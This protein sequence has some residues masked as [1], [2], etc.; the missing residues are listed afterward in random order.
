M[1]HYIGLDVSMKETSVCVINENGKIVKENTIPTEPREIAS[2]INRLQICVGLVGLESGSLSHWLTEELVSIG[3]P[4]KCIDARHCA[5]FLSMRINKTD[6]ND[7]QGIA[8][9][10]RC[11]IFREVQIKPRAV[12]EVSS[13]LTSRKQLVDQRTRMLMSIRGILKPFG[14]RLGSISKTPKGIAKVLEHILVQGLEEPVKIG[15]RSLFHAIQAM[16]TSIAELESNIKKYINSEPRAQLLMTIP[17]VG[18]IT[19]LKYLVEISDPKRFKKSRSVGAYIGLTP[20]QY[21]SGETQKQGKISKCGSKDLRSLLVE[22]AV[23]LLTRAR[24]WS[25]LK[26]WGLRIMK[27]S[28]LKKAATAVARKLAVIMHQMLI[29]EKPFRFSTK[30]QKV[31]M[32]T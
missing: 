24:S 6:R 26:A 29:T 25:Q 8:E 13:L 30:E 12:R 27:R 7:A 4:V 21:A 18:P 1:R 16:T 5:A 2:Y 28:G 31:Q 15:I 20:T 11:G 17:G 32:S 22:A 14:I 3:L 10:M 19:A 23:V 9:V